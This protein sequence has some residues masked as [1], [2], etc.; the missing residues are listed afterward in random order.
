M[1]HI[2]TVVETINAHRQL[3]GGGFEVS[4]PFPTKGLELLDPFLLLDEMMPTS[5]SPGEAIGAPDHPHRGFETVTYV[6]QGEVEHKDS[7]GNHDTISHG[8]V[9]WMTAGAGIVHSEMP[10]KNIQQNGGTLHGFQL[11]VNLPK[12]NKMDAP[13]YQAISDKELQTIERDGWKAKVVAGKILETQ[14]SALTKTPILYAHISIEPGS[15]T[16]FEIDPLLVNSGIYVFKGSA[17]VGEKTRI[18]SQQLGVMDKESGAI[19]INNPSSEESTE[20]LVMA[21]TPLDEPVARS[22]PFVMNTRTELM[23]AFRD[24]SEG[25]MGKIKVSGVRSKN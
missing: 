4:R 7:M 13:K 11:W 25:K 22:G 8:E 21:G 2:K 19:N 16:E 1:T 3:E 15:S 18:D 23:E 17:V 24:Y 10:S 6:L 9:Q 5:Y 14:G 12:A 20:L